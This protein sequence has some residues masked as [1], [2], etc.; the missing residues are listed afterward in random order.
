MAANGDGVNPARDDL[1]EVA[2][3]NVDFLVHHRCLT[4]DNVLEYFK[5]S[6]FYS[7]ESINEI[8]FMQTRWSTVQS[9]QLDAKKLLGFY[10]DILDYVDDPPL[11]TI[12]KWIRTD[13]N[14][15]DLVA[16]YYIT[17]NVIYQAPDLHTLIANRV[18]STLSM[19]TE[20]FQNVIPESTHDPAR[21]H[22][23]KQDV[24]LIEQMIASSASTSAAP[25][26]TDTADAD[27]TGAPNGTVADTSTSDDND[28]D[29]DNVMGI[30]D[31]NIMRDELIASYR[32]LDSVITTGW[33]DVLSDA[34]NG[35]LREG[36]IGRSSSRLGSVAG[37]T[38]PLHRNDNVRKTAA[39]VGSP[40]P[41]QASASNGGDKRR[42]I[43]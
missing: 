35:P 3:K 40:T 30:H 34:S 42:R 6:D 37:D 38:T 24:D 21:G 29:D 2:W 18:S 25:A 4:R 36:A 33:A 9:D 10:Y 1:T 17:D 31:R 26:P 13:E 14:K 22:L 28:D 5:Q 16:V 7:S 32:Y 12:G 41:S 20:A 43:V 23:W 27:V 8:L 15:T 39:R 19:I 11:W